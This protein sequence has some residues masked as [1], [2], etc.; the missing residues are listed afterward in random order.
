MP[1]GAPW[2]FSHG[3]SMA[4]FPWALIGYLWGMGVNVV[5]TF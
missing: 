1:M 2:R 4:F 5:L 3:R